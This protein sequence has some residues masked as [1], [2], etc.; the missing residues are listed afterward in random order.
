MKA[1]EMIAISI[2]GLLVILFILTVTVNIA[3]KNAC[4]ELGYEIYSNSLDVPSC[5]D[6][7]GNYYYVYWEYDKFPYKIK[8]K[9]ISVGDVR[10]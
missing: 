5:R 4:E 9:E 2:I 3:K 6:I 10:G 1:G 8:M 7:D